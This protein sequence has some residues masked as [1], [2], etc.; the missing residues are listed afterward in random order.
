M[1]QKDDKL[2]RLLDLLG[3]DVTETNDVNHLNEWSALMGVT[4]ESFDDGFLDKTMFQI[5]KLDGNAVNIVKEEMDFSSKVV[6]MFGKIAF[7]GAAA[8]LILIG[9][10]WFSEGSVSPDALLGFNQI[11]EAAMDVTSNFYSNY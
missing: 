5:G 7:S 6:Q 2:K 9:Y 10:S 3:E 4:E 11:S 1:E 8:I